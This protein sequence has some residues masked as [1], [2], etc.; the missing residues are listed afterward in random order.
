MSL[1]SRHSRQSSTFPSY[2]VPVVR[3]PMFSLVQSVSI[4]PWEAPRQKLG[5]ESVY[6][7]QARGVG[8]SASF[9]WQEGL[10]VAVH[11]IAVRENF[12]RLFAL[13]S[14]VFFIPNLRL[15]TV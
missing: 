5:D 6:R 13:I 14:L 11:R 15:F 7:S 3:G 2:R 10:N 9:G 8:S 12:P 1:I 4:Q